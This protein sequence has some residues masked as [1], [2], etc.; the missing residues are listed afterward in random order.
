MLHFLLEILSNRFLLF[1]L[2][3]NNTGSFPSPL[4]AAE[5]HECLLACAAGD[6]AARDKLI[7]HNLRLVVHVIKKY[8]A[9]CAEQ[10]DLIS[11]GTIGLIKAINTFNVEKGARLATYAA[12]CIDNEI[13]MYFRN[14]KK[15]AQDVSMSD[16]IDVDNE[17]NPLTLMDVISIDDTIS[18]EIDLK[19]KVEKLYE[20]LGQMKES[21][22]KEILILRY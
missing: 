19:I 14:Q 13:L 1:A 4:N 5:E 6:R 18:D 12:R 17:G 3:L 9:S 11:V 21:R 2:H 7:E 20:Y 15:T 8:Y 16:P 10:D 22:E